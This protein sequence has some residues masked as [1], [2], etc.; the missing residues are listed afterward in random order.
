MLN[1][2]PKQC[3]KLDN[4]KLLIQLPDYGRN[5]FIN[6][7]PTKINQLVVMESD[8]VTQQFVTIESLIDVLK[9]GVSVIGEY[10]L[11]MRKIAQIND[12][13]DD[14]SMASFDIIAEY[15]KLKEFISSVEKKYSEK[16]ITEKN[17]EFEVVGYLVDTGSE[18]IECAASFGKI[19]DKNGFFVLNEKRYAIKCFLNECDKYGIQ[20]PPFGKE[21]F[22]KWNN[23]YVLLG[24][25][26]DLVRNEKKYYFS[27]FQNGFKR[28][29][30]INKVFAD[31]FFVKYAKKQ[32]GDKSLKN[33]C[34]F[35][36]ELKNVIEKTDINKRSTYQKQGIIKR[37][38][39]FKS[40]II[41]D[42]FS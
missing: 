2:Q 10:H 24:N 33:V 40:K 30:E 20:R 41:D 38:N 39:D 16:V 21:E 35:F 9:D 11:A 23:E 6:G 29:A 22:Y 1:L 31:Y 17:I 34:D 32:L 14:I 12:D 3:L 28:M 18:F 13:Y 4:G 27:D 15:A 8:I 26:S 36:E 19:N 7:K 42:C 37:I 5:C 25:V